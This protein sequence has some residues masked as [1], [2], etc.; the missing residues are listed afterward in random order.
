[1]QFYRQKKN[2]EILAA[3]NFLS[4]LPIIPDIRKVFKLVNFI[5]CSLISI[6]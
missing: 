5:Y 1:M 4:F 2:D 3:L 6:E